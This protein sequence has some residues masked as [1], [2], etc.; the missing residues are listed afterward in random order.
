MIRGSLSGRTIL[1]FSIESP[2]KVVGIIGPARFSD[3][4]RVM[5][6]A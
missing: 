2:I 1:I 4:R 5:I 6:L 3:V